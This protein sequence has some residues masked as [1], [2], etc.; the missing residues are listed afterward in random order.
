M[1]VK[2]IINGEI[3]E[4][5]GLEEGRLYTKDEVEK[6]F[7]QYRSLFYLMGFNDGI[8]NAEN[9]EEYDYNDDDCELWTEDEEWY[10]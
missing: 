7:E 1:P 3:A 10:W 4:I 8:K 5:A 2:N 6:I 9:E